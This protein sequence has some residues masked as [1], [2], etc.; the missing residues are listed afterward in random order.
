MPVNKLFDV[1]QREVNFFIYVS[2]YLGPKNL[3][4]FWCTG[5]AWNCQIIFRCASI[6]G[7][8]FHIRF[9][10][11]KILHLLRCLSLFLISF[12]RVNICLRWENIEW[13]PITLRFSHKIVF[14]CWIKLLIYSVLAVFLMFFTIKYN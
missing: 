7:R 10:N 1:G 11:N 5:W 3:D 2:I 13:E 12:Y 4:T 8:A 6:H 14:H 9:Y